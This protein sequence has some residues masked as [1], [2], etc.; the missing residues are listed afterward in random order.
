MAR[1]KR[2]WAAMAAFVLLGVLEWTTLSP[3]TVRVVN[4]PS[5]G[6]LLEVSVRGIAL[7][8]LL[9]FA[10]RSWV[11]YRHQTLAGRDEESSSRARVRSGRE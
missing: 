3:E 5:G 7:A 9:M 1:E 2:F 10:V 6:A 8:V 4:S 11:V